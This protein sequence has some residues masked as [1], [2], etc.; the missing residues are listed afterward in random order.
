MNVE[1]SSGGHGKFV[2]LS[3]DRVELHCSKPAAPGTPLTGVASDGV[4]YEVKVRT[5]KK[6]TSDPLVYWVEGRLLNA[7]RAVRERLRAEL[8]P[9]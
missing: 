5:C 3:G 4:R 6:L 7:T 1:F 9:S 8:E 2:A